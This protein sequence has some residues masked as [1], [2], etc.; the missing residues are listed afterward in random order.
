MKGVTMHRRAF[1]IAA[2]ILAALLLAGQA[3]SADPC[4][5]KLRN[6]G[7]ALV[8][9]AADHGSLFPGNEAFL[10]REFHKYLAKVGE[11]NLCC[12]A[13]GRQYL[14]RPAGKHDFVISC[15]NP[16]KHG[17]ESLSFSHSKGLVR[18][19]PKSAAKKTPATPAVSSGTPA[20][21]PERKEDREAIEA[22]IRDL[23]DA[24]C[25][26]DIDKIMEMEKPFI[27]R[28]AEEYEKS[29]KGT[30]DKMR[31]V[32][33]LCTLDV[34]THK[35]FRMLPLNLKELEFKYDGDTCVV[36]GIDPVI[37]TDRVEVGD[38]ANPMVV[39]LC[40]TQMTFRKEQG[41]WKIVD[42]FMH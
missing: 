38:P 14:Y 9:W 20:Q 36:A 23:Y 25:R 17:L 11:K 34:I 28:A 27:D 13:T 18:V 29:G 10:G 2:V 33:R 12:P 7:N 8:L 1:L 30:A 40:I 35:D 24:Y 22:V 6:I 32:L 19:G 41:S 26:Q 37:A 15:P 4:G 16:A 31:E 3:F 42:M 21:A 5:G 39:R